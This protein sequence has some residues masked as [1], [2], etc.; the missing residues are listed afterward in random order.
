MC[1]SFHTILLAGTLFAVT[2]TVWAQQEFDLGEALNSGTKWAQSALSPEVLNQVTLPSSRD[3]TVFLNNVQQELQTGTIEDLAEWQPYVE[4]GIQL[5][6][7]MDDGAEYAAW[8]RQRLDYFEMASASVETN[9]EPTSSAKSSRA[10]V[11]GHTFQLGP[12]T[13]KRAGLPRSDIRR[14]REGLIRS[15]TLWKQKLRSRALPAEGAVLIPQLKK[16]FREEGVPTSFVWIAE[17]ESSLNPRARNPVGAAGLFQ[18]MPATA[19]RFNLKLVPVDERKD[20]SKSARAAARYLR[21]LHGEF[22]SWP[23]A[24]AAYN[25]G[26]GRIQKALD[27]STTKTF[28]GIVETLPVET[29]MYVPKVSAVIYLREGVDILNMKDNP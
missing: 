8:L 28:E 20:P 1:R 15:T 12:P 11:R 21:F 27:A 2:N 5:L 18:F 29:R 6:S 13:T 26:E 3:W 14:R 24:I 4:L 23:L 17:V 16:A 22:K 19:K 10:L 25:A 9:P 7:R